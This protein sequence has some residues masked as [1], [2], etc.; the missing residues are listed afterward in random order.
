MQSGAVAG[1]SATIFTA[2]LGQR[3]VSYTTP[4]GLVKYTMC[5]YIY[6]SN[7]LPHFPFFYYYIYIYFALVYKMV[8]YY[9]YIFS[10]TYLLP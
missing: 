7:L 1:Q 3:Y 6:I 8:K 10:P 9:I 4:P 2:T 5:I